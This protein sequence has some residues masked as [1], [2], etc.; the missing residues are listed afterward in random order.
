V[1]AQTIGNIVAALPDGTL[2]DVFTAYRGGTSMDIAAMPAID[3]QVIR[4]SDGG[5]TWS[6]PI[7]VAPQAS[8]GV[9]GLR[10]GDGLPEIAVDPTSGALY[11]AWEDSSF[12]QNDHDGIV[13]ARSSDGGLTWSAPVEANG[14]PDV[15]AFTPQIAVASDGTVGV[16]YYDLRADGRA[17]AWLASSHDRGATWSDEQ[18]SGAFD[19][20]I[21]NVGAYAF[22][23]DYEGLV[24]RGTDLV[25]LFAIAFRPEDP[26]DIF[27][28]P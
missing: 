7:E 10:T 4:S 28:R 2:V 24:A 19:Q 14:A 23:G 15:P 8:V 21:A 13:L 11:V 25:P 9:S 1:N 27:V 3:I 17:T 5:T 12:S 16:F 6:Q 26:T 20:T 18:L 22:L